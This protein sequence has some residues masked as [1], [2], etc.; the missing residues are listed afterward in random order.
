MGNKNL[1][2]ILPVEPLVTQLATPGP[3]IDMNLDR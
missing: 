3:L 2:I 1:R